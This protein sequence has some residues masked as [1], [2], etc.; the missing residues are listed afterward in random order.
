MITDSF[1]KPIE[2]FIELSE[3]QV[4]TCKNEMRNVCLL[5]QIS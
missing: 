2:T 1:V 4:D 5:R 3:T